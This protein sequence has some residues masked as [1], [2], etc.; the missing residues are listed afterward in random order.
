MTACSLQNDGVVRWLSRT[1]ASPQVFRYA[2]DVREGDALH[3]LPDVVPRRALFLGNALAILPF[4]LAERFELVVAADC[5]ASRLAFAHQRAQ[6]DG[7]DNL[8]CVSADA[9]DDI[10]SRDGRFDLVVLGEERPEATFSLPLDDPW[11]P[12]RLSSL[13]TEG[14][15]LMY[16]ARFRLVDPIVQRLVRPW[17]RRLSAYYPAQT[18]LLTVAGFAPV[19]VY[20]RRPDTRPYHAYIPLTPSPVVDYWLQY[21]PR[22]RG[23]RARAHAV[24][25]AVA[26]RAGL[27]H[28]IVDNF[29]VIA[30][31]R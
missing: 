3:L 9:V 28:R 10:T 24:L 30:R 19:V 27:L 2:T 31:R 1:T 21:G 11:T 23:A 12:S 8:R 17:R 13:V 4:L 16:G 5:H 7:V 15:W 22:P 26:R 25:T 20:W 14:G 6:E 29:L 18:R